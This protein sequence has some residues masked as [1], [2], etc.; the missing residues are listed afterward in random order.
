MCWYQDSEKVSL[1]FCQNVWQSGG[2]IQSLSKMTVQKLPLHQEG[3][4]W[5]KELPEK[6]KGWGWKEKRRWVVAKWLWP[7]MLG[8][9]LLYSGKQVISR[10]DQM[11]LTSQGI[12]WKSLRGEK[13]VTTR[14][15]GQYSLVEEDLESPKWHRG[16]PL[17]MSLSPELMPQSLQ[18][19][20]Q[21]RSQAI[22]SCFSCDFGQVP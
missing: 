10:R 11:R 12:P 2:I 3:R 14:W 13:Q 6:N 16:E 5:N 1:A 15:T 9:G 8:W 4:S 22:S 7:C 20:D 19:Q 21:S 18:T 17:T